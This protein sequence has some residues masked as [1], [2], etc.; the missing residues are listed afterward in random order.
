MSKSF[1]PQVRL[2]QEVEQPVLEDMACKLQQAA[3]AKGCVFTSYVVACMN[4]SAA[5]VPQQCHRN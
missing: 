2:A 5:A 1:V 4:S 3:E